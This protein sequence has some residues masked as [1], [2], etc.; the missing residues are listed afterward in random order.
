MLSEALA[1]ALTTLA[2]ALGSEPGLEAGAG[3]L[4]VPALGAWLWRAEATF[5]AMIRTPAHGSLRGRVLA[6]RCLEI[7]VSGLP[8]RTDPELVGRTLQTLQPL[9]L[10]PEP[11][12]W[13]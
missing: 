4:E 10:H 13:V 3:A 5:D 7:S 6:A 9:L 2:R 1:A 11:L 12:V 8:P